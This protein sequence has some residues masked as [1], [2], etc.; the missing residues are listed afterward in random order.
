[1]PY[2]LHVFLYC[3][4]FD[5][6]FF[7]CYYQLTLTVFCI[8]ILLS[9][10]CCFSFDFTSKDNLILKEKYLKLLFWLEFNSIAHHIFITTDDLPTIMN[11]KNPK[12]VPFFFFCF[13]INMVI[14]TSQFMMKKSFFSL[15][16][17]KKSS[18]GSYFLLLQKTIVMAHFLK[19]LQSYHWSSVNS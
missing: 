6:I 13:P 12:N 5:S 4:G 2:K 14:E 7:W 3:H 11:F 16:P 18:D 1:M 17:N 8:F 19:K 10:A 15:Q 9:L